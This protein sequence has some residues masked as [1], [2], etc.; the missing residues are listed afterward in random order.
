LWGE[1]PAEAISFL[2]FRVDSAVVE[3]GLLEQEILLLRLNSAGEWRVFTC[4]GLPV[5]VVRVE[6]PAWWWPIRRPVL[7]VHEDQD[8]PLLCTVSPTW[9]F[10]P[11]FRVH[12]ANDSPVGL[13]LEGRIWDPL[14]QRLATLEKD[15][16]LSPEGQTLAEVSHR[17]GQ[18]RLHFS[19]RVRCEPFV[20]MLLLAAVLVELPSGV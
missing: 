18:A 16:F 4:T 2:L 14:G 12:D 19:E 3:T 20:K 8:E 11:W 9:G 17:D 1:Q 15:R 13:V 10:G 5:G 6:R 7:A